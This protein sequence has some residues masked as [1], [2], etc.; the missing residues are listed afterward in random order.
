MPDLQIFGAGIYLGSE[1]TR[2]REGALLVFTNDDPSVTVHFA[3][4]LLSN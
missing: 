2:P 4:K 1:N 3:S